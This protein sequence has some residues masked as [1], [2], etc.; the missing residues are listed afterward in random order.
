MMFSKILS[1]LQHLRMIRNFS[2]SG[3]AWANHTPVSSMPKAP[4]AV[5]QFIQGFKPADI[6]TVGCS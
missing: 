5:T 4:A 2:V 1:G 6:Y 3:V